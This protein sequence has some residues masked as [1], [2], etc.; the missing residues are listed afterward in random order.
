MVLFA[1]GTKPG[2]QIGHSL[3]ELGC[4]ITCGSLHFLFFSLALTPLLPLYVFFFWCCSS[5]KDSDLADSRL[6]QEV[7]A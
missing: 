4:C 2:A 1:I 6:S 7:L 5:H 3:Q